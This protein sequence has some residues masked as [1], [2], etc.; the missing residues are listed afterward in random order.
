MDIEIKTWLYDILNAIQQIES[1]LQIL[2]KNLL[3]IKTTCEQNV[4]LSVT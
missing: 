3:F 1:F 4:P 2:S